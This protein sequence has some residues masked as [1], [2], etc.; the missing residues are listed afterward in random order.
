MMGARV[1]ENGVA[2]AGSQLQSQLWVNTRTD[3][4]NDAIRAE[5][6][7]LADE[8]ITWTSPLAADGYTEYQ[9]KGFLRAVG[10][11]EHGDALAAFWPKRGGPVWDALATVDF[12]DEV[13]VLLAEGKSYPSEFASSSAATDPESIAQ[14]EAALGQT[15]AWLGVDGDPATWLDGYYQTANRLAHLYW[16]REVI[17]I[18][19]WLI[20]L[21]FVDDP[22]QPTSASE[23]EDGVR[24]ADAALGL[25]GPALWAG[26]VLLP[27]GTRDELLAEVA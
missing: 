12:D 17:G 27:A 15:R 8:E 14:I 6:D 10:L 23:W 22:H 4:L 25:Q 13:G 18:R 21:L 20:H 7:D 2:F 19:A 1:D 9:D 16:L 11:E 5:F 26:H 24:T 3:E